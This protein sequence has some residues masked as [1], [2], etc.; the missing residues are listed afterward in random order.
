[1]GELMG[2]LLRLGAGG[3]VLVKHRRDDFPNCLVPETFGVVAG[4][5][6]TLIDDAPNRIVVADEGLAEVELIFVTELCIGCLD[7][8]C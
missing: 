4:H 7:F 6:T 3:L 1:M 2:A 5:L 8:G